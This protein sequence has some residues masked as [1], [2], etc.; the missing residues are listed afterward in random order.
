MPAP[1]K[2]TMGGGISPIALSALLGVPNEVSGH[3]WPGKNALSCRGSSSLYDPKEWGPDTSLGTPD[4]ALSAIGERPP[5]EGRG[6]GDA[7]PR[8]KI[9][10]I[11]SNFSPC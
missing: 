1:C 3:H 11:V 7:M 5:P 10:P 4:N 6:D 8:V 9:V 2:C